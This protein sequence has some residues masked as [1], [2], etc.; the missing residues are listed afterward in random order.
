METR[1]KNLATRSC[2]KDLLS[3]YKGFKGLR[4]QGLGFKTSELEFCWNRTAH[5]GLGASELDSMSHQ[6]G[7]NTYADVFISTGGYSKTTCAARSST[8]P[9]IS[10][11]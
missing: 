8:P 9:G 5:D 10:K 6:S 1:V 11:M 7:N 4:V 2:R 3:V